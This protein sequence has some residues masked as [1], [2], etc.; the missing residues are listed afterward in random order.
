MRKVAN[1]P[2]LKAIVEFGKAD[3][4]V[5]RGKKMTRGKVQVLQVSLSGC[6]ARGRE[7]RTLL[8]IHD[9]WMSRETGTINVRFRTGF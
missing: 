4:I 1:D 6:Q 7:I 5:L 2:L 8:Q 9:F 3:G